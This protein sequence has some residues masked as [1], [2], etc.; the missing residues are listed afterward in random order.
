V[1]W[2]TSQSCNDGTCATVDSAVGTQYTKYKDLAGRTVTLTNHT[3]PIGM[4]PI[5]LEN[6]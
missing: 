1:I 5:L 4:Q 3:A 2:D 6:Q